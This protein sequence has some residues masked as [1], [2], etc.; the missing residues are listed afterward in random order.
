[1]AQVAPG[2]YQFTGQAGPEHGSSTGMRLRTDYLSFKFFH[3]NGWGGEF[4]GDNAFT[5]TDAAKAYVKDA[6]NI[7]LADGVQLEEGATYRITINLNGGGNG[8][9]DMVKL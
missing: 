9:L 1:M 8:T 3:Q 6:G 5:L 2:V 7:E 4:A